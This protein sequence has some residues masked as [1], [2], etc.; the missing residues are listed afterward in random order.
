MFD[1]DAVEKDVGRFVVAALGAGEL[2][3]GGH[4]PP[5]DGG[6]EYG[7]A[8]ALQ[9]ALD[10]LK[11]RDGLVQPTEVRLNDGDD[12]TLL[13]RWRQSD[14]KVRQLVEVHAG[15]I[16]GVQVRR[17]VHE[18]ARQETALEETRRYANSWRERYELS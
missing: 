6:R 11:K 12:P 7:S 17:E 9:I 1:E 10:P 4:Q 13:F 14:P 8:V 5:L 15:P 2:G 16:A 3:L 18:V